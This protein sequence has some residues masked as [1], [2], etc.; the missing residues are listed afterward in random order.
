MMVHSTRIAA[1]FCF[2]LVLS[3]CSGAPDVLGALKR[4]PTA[5][6]QRIDLRDNV[7]LAAPSGWCVDPEAVDAK[8]GFVMLAGCKRIAGE[9]PSKP[10]L[11]A[12]VQVGA[13]GTEVSA[14]ELAEFLKT[15]EGAGLLA[16]RGGASGVTVT[17]VARQGD[18]VFVEYTDSGAAVLRGIVSVGGALSTVSVRA[19]PGGR[20]D[21]DEAKSLLLKVL[22]GLKTR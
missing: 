14:A 3:A 18:T 10:A 8:A 5:G 4:L 17:S 9:A 6:V 12:I 2:A 21:T 13:A 1:L 16:Q 20:V 22:S 7:R 15:D 11:A 19:L